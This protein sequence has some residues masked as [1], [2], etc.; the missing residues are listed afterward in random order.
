M[1]YQSVLSEDIFLKEVYQSGADDGTLGQAI[2]KDTSGPNGIPDGV[3]TTDDITTA[4]DGN[5]E[6]L[7]NGAAV[8]K[9]VELLG[10]PDKI[11]TPIWWDKN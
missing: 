2:Y 4:G 9:A 10:G 11:A 3:I 8:E 7:S 5:S 6:K 1:V